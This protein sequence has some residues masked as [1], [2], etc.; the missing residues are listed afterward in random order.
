MDKVDITVLGPG[1][2]N[3]IRLENMC[4]EA[5]VNIGVQASINK[6]TNYEQIADHGVFLTPGL[7]INGK[8]VLS[9]KMPTR[10][11]LMNWIKTA[12]KE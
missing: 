1:C 5:I 12:A 11:T 2:P 6:I 4:R 9:G 8:L 7:I 10:A 3:C